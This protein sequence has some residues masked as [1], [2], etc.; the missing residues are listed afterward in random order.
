MLDSD[1]VE[2]SLATM[3][4]DEP[5][6]DEL[7]LSDD[8]EGGRQP[9]SASVAEPEGVAALATTGIPPHGGDAFAHDVEEVGVRSAEGTQARL[10]LGCGLE[11]QQRLEVFQFEVFGRLGGG[12]G[13]SSDEARVAEQALLGRR[14]HDCPL[15]SRCRVEYVGWRP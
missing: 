14:E 7:L 8:V 12:L 3:L 10:R 4:F 13:H 15:R 5:D 2:N 1:D 6:H 11:S 9:C